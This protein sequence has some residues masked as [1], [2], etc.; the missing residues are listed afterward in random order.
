MKHAL[1]T[2]TKCLFNIVLKKMILNFLI[3]HVSEY[4]AYIYM[5]I[6]VKHCAQGWEYV[7][8]NLWNTIHLIRKYLI[9]L[10][11]ASQLATFTSSI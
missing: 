9:G 2:D 4:K 10:F 6:K 5:K 11:T 1:S 3:K 8:A 7:E